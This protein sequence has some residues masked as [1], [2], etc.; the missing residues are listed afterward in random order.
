MTA[1]HTMTPETL[2]GVFR[3]AARKAEI[4]AARLLDAAPNQRAARA[5]TVFKDLVRKDLIAKVAAHRGID[6]DA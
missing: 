2:Q 1:Y 5:E 6:L 4:T 3:L